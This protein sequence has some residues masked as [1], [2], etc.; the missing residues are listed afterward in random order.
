MTKCSNNIKSHW[1]QKEI[2]DNQFSMRGKNKELKKKSLIEK[3]EKE[4]KLDW[5]EKEDKNWK[6]LCKSY[7][8]QRER[9]KN[10]YP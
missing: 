3:E 1:P 9:K 8:L 7:S 6:K 4:E 5:K 2:E 10:V